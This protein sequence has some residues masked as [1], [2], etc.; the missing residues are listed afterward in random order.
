MVLEEYNV[1]AVDTYSLTLFHDGEMRVLR[2]Q[3]D[4]V[5][6]RKTENGDS[7]QAWEYRVGRENFQ[8]EGTYELLLVSEDA[9]GKQK[10]ET[11]PAKEPG[12]ETAVTFSV[13]RTAP[14]ALITGAQS[15]GR[16]RTGGAARDSDGAGKYGAGVAEGM[17]RRGGE[18]SM[19]EP[20]WRKNSGSG[21]EAWSLP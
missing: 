10:W 8:E 13:D 7:W 6:S 9:A 21:A 2:E 12:R 19:K 4:F 17:R 3:E 1:D 20:F 11:V 14:E 18:G 5:R 16:Y 15:G